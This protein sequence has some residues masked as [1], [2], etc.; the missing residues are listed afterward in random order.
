[1]KTRFLPLLIAVSAPAAYGDQAETLQYRPA[2]SMSARSASDNGFLGSGAQPFT[3]DIPAVVADLSSTKPGVPK[4]GT[5]YVL[6]F[7]VTPGQLQ[8]EAVN[9]GYAARIRLN[10]ANAL[11]LR[12]HLAFEG[13]LPAVEL[14]IQGSQ[15]ATPLAAID[16]SAIHGGELWLPI[17]RGGS[18]DLELFVAGTDAS[19]TLDLR[20]DQINLILV[21]PGSSDAS[22]ITPLLMGYAKYK[23]YDLACWSKD[24][25][26]AAMQTAAGATALLTFVEDGS[27]Y[28]CSGTLLN[29]KGNT[30]TPWFA[31]ANHCM[32]TQNVANTASFEWFFQ[33]TACG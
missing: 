22:G 13:A 27:S 1:M 9:G 17:T 21:D 6:P 25:A 31:T 33:A 10:T 26:Y 8:W 18:A 32:P 11:R 7:P 12:L 24:P 23:E 4:T 28:I 14:R 29:D 5:V 3:L 16:N 20:L 19:D 2:A 15:D 30:Q